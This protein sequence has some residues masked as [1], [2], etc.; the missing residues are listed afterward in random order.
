MTF[1]EAKQYFNAL[2]ETASR[3]TNDIIANEA[4]KLVNKLEHITSKGI[5]LSV[6]ELRLIRYAQE[7]T[8]SRQEQTFTGKRRAYKR[9]K[10][11]SVDKLV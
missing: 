8:G 2:Y 7:K 3:D 6:A 4:S 10:H 1:N 11:K 5:E 9:R